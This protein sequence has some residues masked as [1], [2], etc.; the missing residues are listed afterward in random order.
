MRFIPG[1]GKILVKV[2]EAPTESA[3]GILLPDR[4][5]EKPNTGEVVKAFR[6]YT[7]EYGV[8]I[9]CELEEGDTVW[10]G[11]Y[12]G[13]PIELDNEEYLILN[14]AELLGYS[15]EKDPVVTKQDK[16]MV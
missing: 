14:F 16:S 1:K 11:K 5:Q 2:H 6:T 3:G 4:S 13:Q 7:S 9:T 15:T 8:P 12:S 10:Y